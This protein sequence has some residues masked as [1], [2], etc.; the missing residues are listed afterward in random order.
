MGFGRG[1][2]GAVGQM[3]AVGKTDHH[4]ALQILAR[5]Q[6]FQAGGRAGPGIGIAACGTI[7][8]KMAGSASTF[9]AAR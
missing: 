2:A 3:H 4:H 7:T 5:G 9:A 1:Q 6:G 8:A